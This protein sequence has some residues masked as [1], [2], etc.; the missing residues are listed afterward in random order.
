MSEWDARMEALVPSLRRFAW[1]LT[2]N[3]DEADDLV[4]DCLEHALGAWHRRNAE[5]KLR[6]WLFTI[7][8]NLHVSDRRRRARRGRL[9][10]E[11]AQFEAGPAPMSGQDAAVQCGQVLA[12][13]DTLPTEQRDVL[14]LVGVEGL[15]Y[16]EAARVLGV[17]PGTVMSRLS[18]G[19]ER[20]RQM[21][22]GRPAPVAALRRVV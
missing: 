18:R 6:A 1:S 5:G 21:A 12:Q 13:L 8:Y 10:G 20:L 9:L 22:E 15:G 4:Q 11:M 7:L 3:A 14:L 19:R 2:R 17:P 16:E